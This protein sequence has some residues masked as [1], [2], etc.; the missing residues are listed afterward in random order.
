M[1]S[2]SDFG[3]WLLR[4][5]ILLYAISLVPLKKDYDTRLTYIIISAF[6]A[7]FMFSIELEFLLKHLSKR[8]Q[9]RR[10]FGFWPIKGM[11]NIV[12]IQLHYAA[13]KFNQ[14]TK[15]QLKLYKQ[16]FIT[17]KYLVEEGEAK[18]NALKQKFWY[19]HDLA[20]FFQFPVKPQ[21]GDYFTSPKVN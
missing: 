1:K 18:V 15:E 19:L 4:I 21:I 11:F 14:C 12:E 8:I 10:A 2:K 7:I 9:F 13:K 3:L 20:F 6:I 16:E 17:L 5:A